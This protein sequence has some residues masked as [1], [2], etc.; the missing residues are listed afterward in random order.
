[1]N[2][3]TGFGRAEKT[4]Q[5]QHLTIEMKSVNHRYLE[6]RF[7]LPPGTGSTELQ[8]NELLRKKCERGSF[9]ISV[10]T[11]LSPK[12]GKL[13]G[14]TRYVVDQTALTSLIKGAKD[15]AKQAGIK[16]E[17]TLEMLTQAG[18]VFVA[19]EDADDSVLAW[20]AL[21]PVAEAALKNLLEMRLDE[22]KKIKKMLHST[23]ESFAKDL[24]GIEALAS[25]QPKR[26][27]ERLDARL[28]T[29]ALTTPVD[30]SRLEWEVAILAEKSDI[31][32]EID[33]LHS[34]LK[35]FTSALEGKGPVGRK[36]D[37]LTQELNR[38]VNTIASK[39]NLLE[40][41]RH[42]IDLKSGIEKL[43]EQIQNVE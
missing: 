29:W 18:R 30:T 11:R 32:E 28:K 33:R 2:S 35:A 34:H 12:S 9:D 26:I 37:F 4:L 17:L 38:E 41:T 1:M 6:A 25:E 7:R 14:R 40:I 43:R 42:T 23:M 19:V 21:K 20:D 24:K 8:L 22:G 5:D 27:Q 36:L 13:S 16:G 15:A 39:T 3:M 10:R 31:T